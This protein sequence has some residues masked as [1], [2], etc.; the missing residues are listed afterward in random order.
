[1]VRADS[2][3]AVEITGD[4]RGL[5]KAID[6]SEAE[7]KGFG[8][9]AKLLGGALAAG[10]AVDAVTDFAKTALAEGDRLGDASYDGPVLWI[11]GAGSDY[12]G[13]DHGAE[14]DRRFPRNRRVM[15]K[16]A[17]HWVHSEQPQSFLAVLQEF[18]G[19]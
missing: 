16:G 9:K 17:G 18:L 15:V 14:M 5:S 2:K 12:V 11:G 1:M 6:K 7:V 10:F 8:D 13:D 19:D 3:V 4:A